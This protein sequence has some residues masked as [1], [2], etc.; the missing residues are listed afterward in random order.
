M[1]QHSITQRNK[2]KAKHKSPNAISENLRFFQSGLGMSFQSVSKGR[3]HVRAR[4]SLFYTSIK[5]RK[6]HRE[7]Y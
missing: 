2:S 3:A 4:G 5:L 7:G 1:K 6:T